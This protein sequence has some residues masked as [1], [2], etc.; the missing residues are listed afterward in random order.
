MKPV[1]QVR[2]R[3]VPLGKASVLPKL[4]GSKSEVITLND[5]R[6][7]YVRIGEHVSPMF[8]PGMRL[9]GSAAGGV[10]RDWRVV[11]FDME[12]GEITVEPW[13]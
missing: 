10:E 6:D 2:R 5:K 8:E 13:A 1:E 3:R 11:S 4:D 9:R 7:G 12:R